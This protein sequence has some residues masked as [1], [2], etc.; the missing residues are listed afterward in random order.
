MSEIVDKIHMILSRELNLPSAVLS[1]RSRLREDL[2]M[3]S[4][5]ALNLIFAAEKELDITIKE[6]DIIELVTVSDLENLVER[7]SAK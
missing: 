7:L 5:I 1:P 6:E 3:D 2:N 4:I